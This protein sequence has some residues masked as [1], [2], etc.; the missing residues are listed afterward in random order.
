MTL[1][2][3]QLLTDD[4]VGMALYIISYISPP[5]VPPGPFEDPKELTWFKHNFLIQKLLD[6]FQK[7][8]PEFHPVYKSLMEKLGVAVEINPVTI[9][10]PITNSTETAENSTTSSVES[11]SPNISL[12]GSL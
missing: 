2:Q 3:L 10:T 1:N 9:P 11:T 8:N 7:I 4:E 5:G 12:T 6:A